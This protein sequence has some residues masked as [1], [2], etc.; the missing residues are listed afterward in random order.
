MTTTVSPPSQAKTEPPPA[1]KLP[2]PHHFP[3]QQASAQ[4]T[5]SLL[6]SFSVECKG[7]WTVLLYFS[8]PSFI[9]HTPPLPPLPSSSF[10]CPFFAESSFS[11]KKW[12]KIH[13]KNQTHKQ[14]LKEIQVSTGAGHSQV[15]LA[16]LA[17]V[18]A[19][20]KS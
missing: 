6:G 16:R 10:S 11:G 1:K 2:K 7:R 8:C 14:Y 15:P 3:P 9:P 4:P 12:E 18:F 20:V 5:P 19:G 13:W 17:A